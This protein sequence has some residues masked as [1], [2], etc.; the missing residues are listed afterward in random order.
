MCFCWNKQN[1]VSLKVSACVLSGL[2]QN[3]YDPFPPPLPLRPGSGSSTS[4]LDLLFC[5]CRGGKRSRK[6]FLAE[7]RWGQ[8]GLRPGGTWSFL[9]SGLW[10]ALVLVVPRLKDPLT[11]V[12]FTASFVKKQRIECLSSKISLDL[13]F[14]TS[15][16]HLNKLRPVWTSLPGF[17]LFRSV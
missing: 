2:L 9:L 5:S 10:A 6:V 7:G 15:T 17:D 13:F 8:L 11:F 3:L 1:S 14:Y 16:N 12:C 4:A